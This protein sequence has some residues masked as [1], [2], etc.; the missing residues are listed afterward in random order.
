MRLGASNRDAGDFSLAIAPVVILEHD[1]SPRHMI[2]D[3]DVLAGIVV[4][5]FHVVVDLLCRVVGGGFTVLQVVEEV[6]S[7]DAEEG[8]NHEAD[9][10]VD[11][12]GCIGQHGGDVCD[13]PCEQVVE[14][15]RGV[16]VVERFDE[17]L[18]QRFNH[19][20]LSFVFH[21]SGV[22]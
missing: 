22:M 19:D 5:D 4:D 2:S 8:E 18:D 17:R 7:P 16:R 14:G 12:S 20:A 11:G 21:V 9:H 15:V 6:H 13:H 1:S 10:E 3:S